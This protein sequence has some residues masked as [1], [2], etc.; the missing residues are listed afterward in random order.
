MLERLRSL[1][2]VISNETQ[3]FRGSRTIFEPPVSLGQCEVR[4]YAAIGAYTYFRSGRIATLYRIGRFCSVGP[5]VSIGDGNHPTHF[6]ST[7]P[8]QYGASAFG[9]WPELRDFKTELQL[10]REVAKSAPLIGNDVWIGAGVTITRGVTVGDGA[11]IAAGAVVTKDVEP[12]S[13]VGGVPARHLRYRFSEDIIARLKAVA[14]WNYRPM[15]LQGVPFD[16]VG[17][18]LDEIERRKSEGRLRKSES[19][20]FVVDNGQISPH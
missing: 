10:P 6:L 1:G 7:H 8:F 5:D 9:H 2:V 17:K 12:Y 3:L 11:I 20:R 13:I 19:K 15:D 4:G 18:A 16:D 14:W